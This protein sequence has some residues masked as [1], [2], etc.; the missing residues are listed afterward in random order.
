MKCTS[1]NGLSSIK[2]VNVSVPSQTADSTSSSAPTI[3]LTPDQTISYGGTANISWNVT[4]ST[5][6]RCESAGG[7]LASGTVI[8][9]SG[10]WTTPT[11]YTNTQYGMRCVNTSNGLTTYKYTNVYVATPA[12]PSVTL[13]SDKAIA[14]YGGTATLSWSATPSTNVTCV[15]AGGNIA[16][17]TTAGASGSWTTSPLYT[18]T[19]YGLRCT[20]QT[21]G[22]STTKYVTVSVASQ[23][24]T[25]AS[26]PVVTVSSNV[27]IPYGG[28]TTLRWSVTPTTNVSCLVAGGNLASG[29]SAA[30]S[31]WWTTPNLYTTTQYGIQCTDSISG[32]STT[33]YVTVTVSPQTTTNTTTS[34]PDAC[35][36]LD[37]SLYC[38]TE[39]CT[40][41]TGTVRYGTKNC[42]VDACAAL[43]ASQYCTTQSCTTNTGVVR[44]G[45]KSCPTSSM[46]GAIF[47]ANNTMSSVLGASTQCVDLPT[48]MHRGYESYGVTRL[49]EFLKSKNF[50]GEVTGFYG[51]KTVVA[52]K[53]YQSTRGLLQTGMVYDFTRAA[54][55]ADTCQ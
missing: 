13:T 6:I 43:D 32:Y 30:P 45:T 5:G 29:T 31:G 26:A 9:A 51:D 49:Q 1:A 16:S 46:S 10:S 8:N 3:T 25:S 41:N 22:L 24:P 19:Q 14:T 34:S 20:N 35:A 2:F 38:T 47:A 50:M 53:E 39:S 15:A 7:N 18:T 4:P 33:K 54:I 52:V 40:T 28:N 23:A 11:L 44:Y 17:G 27:T 37:A 55:K 42:A 48:D 36:A 21:N 12:A